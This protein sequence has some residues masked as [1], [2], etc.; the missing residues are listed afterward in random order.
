MLVLNLIL[1]L[2]SLSLLHGQVNGFFELLKILLT[3]QSSYA[4]MVLLSES[5][6][7][8]STL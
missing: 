2:L 1:F 5:I 8:L 3:M 7:T 4:C 6:S